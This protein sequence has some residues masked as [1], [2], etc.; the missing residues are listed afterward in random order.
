MGDKYCKGRYKDKFDIELEEVR[1]MTHD[2][3]IVYAKEVFGRELSKR[4][5]REW[6]E[7]RVAYMVLEKHRGPLTGRALE[8]VRHLDSL[9]EIDPL[10]KAALKSSPFRRTK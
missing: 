3:L 8:R 4:M 2:Q 6:A 5:S 7:R 10:A 1:K 9:T